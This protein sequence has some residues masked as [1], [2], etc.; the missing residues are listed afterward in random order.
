MFSHPLAKRLTTAV[1]V[2]GPN[3]VGRGT[4]RKAFVFLP[5]FAVAKIV[6]YLSP[7]AIAAIAPPETYAAIELAYATGLLIAAFLV[8]APLGGVNQSYLIRGERRVFDQISL[9][10]IL[11]V[12]LC[13]ALLGAA[14][15]VDAGFSRLVAI[16]ICASAVVHTVLSSVFRMLGKRNV[17]VWADGTGMIVA[18]VVVGVVMAVH[19]RASLPAVT[20]GYA[21]FAVAALI[22]SLFVLART[23]SDNLTTRLMQSV[24]VGLPMVMFGAVSMGLSAGSRVLVGMLNTTDLPIYTFAF[25]IAGIGLVVQQIATTALFANI[26]K[27]ETKQADRLLS[28]FL[29]AAA[30]VLVAVELMGAFLPSLVDITA[31]RGHESEFRRVLPV[32]AIQI[33]YW[34]G[35][36]MQTGRINRSLISRHAIIPTSAITIVGAAIILIVGTFVSNDI[37]ILS[38]LVAAYAAAYFLNGAI[39]LARHHQSHRTLASVG[40]AGGLVLLMTAAFA[41]W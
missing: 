16:A 9:T 19:G 28:A 29:A 37:Y 6:I 13:L 27:A 18:G 30:G 22:V 33:F 10:T 1:G 24:R 17:A 41:V 8:G 25:R 15:F 36:S 38:C 2:A 14:W 21:I 35:T 31:I 7:L 5:N 40:I 34:I 12:A 11:G 3:G 23:R 20:I 4:L 39:V 32:V 26:Y